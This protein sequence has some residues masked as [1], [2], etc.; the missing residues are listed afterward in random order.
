MN[1]N[2]IYIEE[3]DIYQYFDGE[4]SV[5]SSNYSVNTAGFEIPAALAVISKN[6]NFSVIPKN[7]FKSFKKSGLNK[8]LSK[9][10]KNESYFYIG[11]PYNEYGVYHTLP[12]NIKKYYSLLSEIDFII[13]YDYL[14]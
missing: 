5:F 14:A 4:K 10:Y 7:N 13:P 11:N 9:Y 8:Y 12:L 2:L 3:Y 1:K 6:I